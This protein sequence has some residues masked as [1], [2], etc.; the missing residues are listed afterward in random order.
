MV[1]AQPNKYG[2]QNDNPFGE[3]EEDDEN[4]FGRQESSKNSSAVFF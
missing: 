4:P 2:Q 3:A 1:Q